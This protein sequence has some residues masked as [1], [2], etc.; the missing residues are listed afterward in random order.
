MCAFIVS[1]VPLALFVAFVVCAS[2]SV[3][4]TC[5]R[6]EETGAR[7]AATAA[8][9]AAG[10]AGSMRRGKA[11]PRVERLQAR[12]R[13]GPQHG[14]SDDSLPPGAA[15][16][17][18]RR[19]REPRLALHPRELRTRLR[20][21]ARH[22]VRGAE[23]R[24]REGPGGLCECTVRLLGRCA[25]PARSPTPVYSTGAPRVPLRRRSGTRRPVRWTCET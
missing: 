24:H 2:C 25:P 14:A 8:A 10:A 7:G 21:P 1:S 12:L 5:S 19:R 13:K 11:R 16:T 23:R 4:V 9:G 18:L 22:R 17:A 15:V 3:R 6:W 20:P